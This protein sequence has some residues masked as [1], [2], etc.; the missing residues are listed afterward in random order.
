MGGCISTVDRA[1]KAKSDLID[2]QIEEDHKKYKRECKILL[3]G[4]LHILSRD[5]L[6]WVAW[7][8]VWASRV[9]STTNTEY[10]DIIHHSRHSLGLELSEQWLTSKIL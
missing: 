1:G 8:G 2:K 3:L 9:P 10:N 6:C 5:A 7:H 4:E